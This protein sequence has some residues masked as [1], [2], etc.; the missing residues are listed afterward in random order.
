M[1]RKRSFYIIEKVVEGIIHAC[2]ATAIVAVTLIM[3]FLL[4][5]GLPLFKYESVRDFFFGKHWFPL[6][7]EFEILPLIM[8]SLIVTLGAIIV[9]VPIGVAC[10]IYIAEVAP[11]RI[12]DILKPTVEILAG[13]PSVVIGFIGLVILTPIIQ[14]AF[15]LSTGQ[16]ALAGSIM[17]AFMAMP[18][19]ISISEDAIVA[20]P[21][22]YREASFAMGATHWQTISGVIVPAAKS[23][24]LA[25]A[26][27]G[28]GRAVGETMTVLMVTG[29]A[30]VFP[31]LKNWFFLQPI[32]TMTAT[33][34]LEMGETVHHSDHYYAL[35]AV[36]AALF[37]ITFVINLIADLALQRVRK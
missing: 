13:I 30:A 34:A 19:I 17:L 22:S 10:A 6:E 14:H 15:Q 11:Q 7:G 9:A 24:I 16:T 1:K 12:R 25:A 31:E 21:H 35:F 18:T 26:M 32:R 36:G 28:V 2:G 29:N 8:A 5:D 4:K 23:G 27:L 20:V 37:F 33:I 3:I